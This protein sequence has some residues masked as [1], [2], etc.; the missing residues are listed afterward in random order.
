MPRSHNSS[1]P[2][3]LSKPPM[4]PPPI[5]GPIMPTQ[6]STVSSGTPS[7]TQS[8]KE[9]FSFGLG[10]S[11][12]RNVVDRMF[13]GSS[14]TPITHH[15]GPVTQT[16]EQKSCSDLLQQYNTCSDTENCSRL[17]EVYQKCLEKQ[18]KSNTTQ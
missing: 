13:G 17:F 1:K 9:G 8:V 7:F 14:T 6:S 3:F 15:V 10:A 11:V 12:A 5:M 16:V 18:N 2:A 4:R